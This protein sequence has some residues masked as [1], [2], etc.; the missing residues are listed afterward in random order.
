MSEIACPCVVHIHAVD[1]GEEVPGGII[2]GVL[3][4]LC[5]KPP[6]WSRRSHHRP[7][8][9]CLVSRL[10]LQ[11]LLSSLCGLYFFL[12]NILFYLSFSFNIT[13]NDLYII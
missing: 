3:D 7:P 8:Q 5:G 9:G 4:M 10:G 12:T 6:E 13:S 1:H 2:T 11:A